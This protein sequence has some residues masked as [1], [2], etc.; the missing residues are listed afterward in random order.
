[1]TIIVPSAAAPIHRVIVFSCFV[2]GVCSLAVAASMPAI[3]PTSASAPL[4]VTS[5]M[6]LPCVTGVF[7]NAMFVRSPG[8]SS[9]S[10]SAS[11]SFDAG[12]LS[13]VRA[14][15]SMS[16]ELAWM[17][18]PSA[19]TSSPALSSTTSP[20]TTSSAGIAASTPSRRTRARLL[21]QRF[22]RVHRALGLA[23]LAEADDGVEHGQQE[24]Q[25]ARAPLADGERQRRR[26]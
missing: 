9:A 19:A 14:D 17:I 24:Q 22:Q 15:S 3:L 20:M 2:S 7:M 23:L 4:A 25:G 18:L 8:P 6:P 13:P 21:R 5:I 10:A 12:V 1:M 11:V 26:R 16:S